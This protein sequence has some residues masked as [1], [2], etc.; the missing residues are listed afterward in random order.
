MMISLA[1]RGTLAWRRWCKAGLLRP[2]EVGRAALATIL[3]A[4]FDATY[5]HDVGDQLN[6]KINLNERRAR[7]MCKLMWQD[8]TLRLEALRSISEQDEYRI[9]ARDKSLKHFC[10]YFDQAVA[11]G[12][13]KG[14]LV[15]R[16]EGPHLTDKGVD[17]A[18]RTRVG[19][20]RTRLS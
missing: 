2:R 10:S 15:Q 4:R 9:R 1:P 19:T 20:Q 3:Q 6:S 11:L 8:P 7:L 17:I 5:I 12:V 18:K 13:K 14:W 16:A